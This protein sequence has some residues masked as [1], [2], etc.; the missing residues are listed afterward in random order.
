M[1]EETNANETQAEPK[2]T[3]WKAKY[4][5]MRAHS[6]EWERKAKDNQTAAD[7]LE[8]LKAASLTEQEKAVRRAEKAEADLR[9]LKAEM[10]RN[11]DAQEVAAKS[12]VPLTLLMH[13]RDREDMEAFAKEYEAETHVP[14]APPAPQSNVIRDGAGAAS[15]RDQFGELAQMFFN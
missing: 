14:A 4:E 8:Q 3:D 9:A 5:A 1:A 10:Q 11:T 6:R 2:E 13:C 15:T 12:G 7:E